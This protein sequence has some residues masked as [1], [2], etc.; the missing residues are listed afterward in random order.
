MKTLLRIFKALLIFFLVIGIAGAGYLKFGLPNIESAP[1]IAIELTPERVERGRYLAHHVSVCMDC[2]STRDW[3]LFSAPPKKEN[4][5]AGGE[6]FSPAEGF[7]GNFYAKNITPAVLGSWT[8]GEIV[9]AITT[10]VSKDGEA[11]FPVMPYH[12][13]GKMDQEDIYSIVAYLR[14]LPAVER[15]IPE[16]SIDFPVNLI[17]N[18]MPAPAQFTSKPN[19]SETLAYGKYLIGAAACVECHSNTKNGQRIP[20][21]EF[22]GGMEFKYEA[23]VTRSANITPDLQTGIG[24]WDKQTFVQRFK[25]YGDSTFVLPTIGAK[26]LN[27]PM[28]WVMYAGLSTE[29]LE[30]MFTYLQSLPPIKHEVIKFDHNEK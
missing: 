22:G 28:P 21:S 19:P 10:G 3:T 8:D 17:I 12:A 26:D 4:W 29:D 14:T 5:G 2:H 1:T 18:T 25:S 24:H 6:K 30:A 20:G 15:E 27:S 16:R 11:L 23:G 13:F 9:R 7:P